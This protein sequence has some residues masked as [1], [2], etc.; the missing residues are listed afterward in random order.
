MLNKSKKEDIESYFLNKTTNNFIYYIKKKV[1]NN[2]D[3]SFY[4][5][6]KIESNVKITHILFSDDLSGFSI[7]LFKEDLQIV[8][9]YDEYKFFLNKKYKEY[10]ENFGFILKENDLQI[11]HVLIINKSDIILFTENFFQGFFDGWLILIK[12]LLRL[13]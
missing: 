7:S 8:I 5:E 3:I 9:A 10:V 6:N 12:D 13:N 1:E 11:F 2:D 4:Q